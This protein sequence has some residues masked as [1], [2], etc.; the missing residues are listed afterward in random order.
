MIYITSYCHATDAKDQVFHGE[1][2]IAQAFLVDAEYLI[3]IRGLP[4]P[5]KSVKVRSLHHV[6]TYLR[7]MAES[8]CGCALLDICPDRPSSSLLSIESSPISLRSFRM[9]HD[10]LDAEIDITLEKSNNIGQNDIHLEVMGQWKDTLLPD[11]YGIPESL[12][13]LLSQAIRLANEQELLHRGPAMDVRVIEELKR[14]ASTLEQYILSWEP[15]SSSLPS[16]VNDLAIKD[17]QNSQNQAAYF[18]MRALHQALVL[19][20]YRRVPNISALMLQDTVRN[21]LH[22]LMR[23]DN[24]RVE[25]AS[26]DKTILWPGFVAACEALDPDLQH[27][28]L[29][30]LVAAGHRTSLGP[31]S[32]AAGTAQCVWKAREETKDYTLSWFDVMKHERCPIIAT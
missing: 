28:L 12:M 31:F 29:D 17:A 19:F 22:F 10:S 23:Y 14:R 5:H 8:T 24:A 15:P 18:M 11:I 30:W 13:T 7:I 21:C 27:G 2:S 16:L 6:Y 3:R 4:K 20:Y 9:A 32:A 1:N 26:R 25:S